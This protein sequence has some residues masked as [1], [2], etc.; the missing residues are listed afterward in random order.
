MNLIEIISII[1]FPLSFN[2][3]MLSGEQEKAGIFHRI[4]IFRSPTFRYLIMYLSILFMIASGIVMLL[5]SWVL[6]LCLFVGSGV[7]YPFIGRTLVIM[8]L[9]IP[10]K[11]LDN[12]ARKKYGDDI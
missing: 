12:I 9:Y 7:L 6:L 4:D 1:V 5:H 11:Y 3:F 10:W 8:L 2:G